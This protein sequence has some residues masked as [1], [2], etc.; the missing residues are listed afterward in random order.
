MIASSLLGHLVYGALVGV[1]Y[2]GAATA[3]EVS[4]A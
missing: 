1:V 2:R 3:A 4:R